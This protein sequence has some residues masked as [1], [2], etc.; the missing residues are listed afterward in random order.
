MERKLIWHN[1][2]LQTKTDSEYDGCVDEQS[3]K[4]LYKQFGTEMSSAR[5]KQAPRMIRAPNYDKGVL[6]HPFQQ[7][8][9]GE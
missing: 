5:K 8:E 9:M 3:D 4:H 2:R 1:A 7:Q 6:R